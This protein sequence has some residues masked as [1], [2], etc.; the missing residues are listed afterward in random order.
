MLFFDLEITGLGGNNCGVVLALFW[1]SLFSI[2][3]FGVSLE[4]TET[5]A[6]L[7]LK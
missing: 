7:S 1:V 2:V 5:L 6:M 4:R 3:D